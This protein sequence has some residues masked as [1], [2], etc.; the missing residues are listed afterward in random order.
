MSHTGAW[1]IFRF[2][3]Y[4]P[5]RSLTTSML[6]CSKR[7]IGFSFVFDWNQAS[8]NMKIARFECLGKRSFWHMSHTVAGS[9]Q[10]LPVLTTALKK[11]RETGSVTVVAVLLFFEF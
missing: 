6:R 3:P 8:G 7:Q 11:A 1:W 4:K 10:P 2:Q 9:I 5:N